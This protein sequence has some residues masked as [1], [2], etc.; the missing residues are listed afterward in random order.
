MCD[1]VELCCKKYKAY[2]YEDFEAGIFGRGSECSVKA[3]G[4]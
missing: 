3:H 4:V 1:D 2:S